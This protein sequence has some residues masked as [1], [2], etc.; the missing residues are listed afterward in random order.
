MAAAA[1]AAA[2]AAAAAS[3]AAARSLGGVDPSA[4]TTHLQGLFTVLGSFTMVVVVT[5]EAACDP[6]SAVAAAAASL[7]F[8]LEKKHV[9]EP[10]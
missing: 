2:A 10:C 4:I 7:A 8:E 5:G 6:P 1:V 9:N 3:A